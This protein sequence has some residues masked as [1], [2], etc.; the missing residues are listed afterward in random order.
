MLSFNAIMRELSGFGSSLGLHTHLITL[1]GI[2]EWWKSCSDSCGKNKSPREFK[3]LHRGFRVGL[4]VGY[5][6]IKG[7]KTNLRRWGFTLPILEA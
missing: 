2:L 1:T 7:T 3:S 4:V 6:K 5:M